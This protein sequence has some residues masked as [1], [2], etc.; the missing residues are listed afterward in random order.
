[1][2]MVVLSK[3]LPWQKLTDTQQR[4]SRVA[5]LTVINFAAGFGT[6]ILAEVVTDNLGWPLIFKILAILTGHV[7]ALIF[8]AVPETTYPRR[9]LLWHQ[10][11]TNSHN[12]ETSENVISA[13][14]TRLMASVEDH[15]SPTRMRSAER[16]LPIQ[17]R[18]SNDNLILV[19][20][21]PVILILSITLFYQ[22]CW[23]LLSWN[24]GYE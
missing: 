17:K 24:S 2:C 21:R 5:V 23:L 19:F 13:F 14:P 10:E 15:V 1:M 4:G 6:P 16:M 3:I 9:K 20:L 8:F 22:E 12:L 11:S 7:I 18:E